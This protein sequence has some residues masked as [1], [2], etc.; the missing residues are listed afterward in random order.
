[1]LLLLLTANSSSTCW[2]RAAGVLQTVRGTATRQSERNV[3]LEHNGLA[4]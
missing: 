2:L 1:M 3:K 4:A